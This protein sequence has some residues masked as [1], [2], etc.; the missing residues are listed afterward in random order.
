MEI[1][2]NKRMFNNRTFNII[3]ISII[4]I[5]LFIMFILNYQSHYQPYDY[6]NSYG[7]TY[8]TLPQ[9]NVNNIFDHN[10]KISS[11]F[12]KVELVVQEMFIILAVFCFF[13]MIIYLLHFIINYII[14]RLSLFNKFGI[15]G[16]N[17]IHKIHL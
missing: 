13:G 14:L 16:F 5:I 2:I 11:I 17:N 6:S 15:I 4:L 1:L 7:T 10:S 8:Y 3:A 12:S 9:N